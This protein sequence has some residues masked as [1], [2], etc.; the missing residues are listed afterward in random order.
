MTR[1]CRPSE[2]L[3]RSKASEMPRDEAKI[4]PV[5]RVGNELCRMIG[6]EKFMTLLDE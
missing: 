4:P 6:A 5:V 2:L 1:G 3:C